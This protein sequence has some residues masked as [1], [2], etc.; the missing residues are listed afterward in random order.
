MR[1]KLASLLVIAAGVATAQLASAADIPAPVYKASPAKVVAYNWT[2]LY[3]GGHA[4]GAWSRTRFTFNNTDGADPFRHNATSWIAGGQVGYLHQFG[5]VVVG[6]EGSYSAT[7]LDVASPAILTPDRS[8]TSKISDLWTVVGRLGYASD[9]WL[10]Y[11]KGGYANGNVKFESFQPS[12]GLQ[13]STSKHREDGWTVG[14]G[15]EYAVWQNVS[16]ALEYAFYRLNI[17]NRD[18]I[19]LNG[20]G[21]ATIT[22]AKAD[23]HAVTAR[24]NFRFAPP[25]P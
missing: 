18:V 15:L 19:P 11:V 14:A 25:P 24:V 21:P 16:F 12:T 3:V 20:F 5:N 10:A 7:D 8:R 17:D 23:I 9:R 1:F 2:G 4:G 6:I 22:D 13:A